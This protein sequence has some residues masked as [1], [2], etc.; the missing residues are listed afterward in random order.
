MLLSRPVLRRVAGATA[1]ALAVGIVPFVAAA[2]T[3]S[4]ASSELF[5]SEYVEGSSNNKAIEIYNGTGATVNM[6][7]YSL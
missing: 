7:A 4:A 3:A 2:P 6:S 5:I 1:A